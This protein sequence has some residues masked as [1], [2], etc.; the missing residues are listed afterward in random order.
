MAVPPYPQWVCLLA[1]EDSGT[2]FPEQGVVHLREAG[3]HLTPLKTI[4]ELKE[5]GD[6]KFREFKQV[7]SNLRSRDHSARR[8]DSPISELGTGRHDGRDWEAQSPLRKGACLRSIQWKVSMSWH[9]N[10]WVELARCGPRPP[11]RSQAG[12]LYLP[13]F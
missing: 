9:T 6:A 3:R 10:C 1:A 12:F 5:L 11:N 8:W 4:F 7:T 13:A 2:S